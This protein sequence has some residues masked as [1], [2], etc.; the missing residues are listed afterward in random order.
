MTTTAQTWFFNTPE[1]NSY[2]IGERIRTSLWDARFGNIWLETV[3]SEAPYLMRGALQGAE[4][5]L[6]WTPKQWCILRTKPAHLLLYGGIKN[7]LGFS[8][9]FKYETPN[10]FTA[11]EWRLGDIKER[12]QAIQG[13]PEFGKLQMIT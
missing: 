12:W 3:R 8:A 11:W 9:L 10:G 4:V 1:N 6:E 7:I 13:K 2:L 5:E